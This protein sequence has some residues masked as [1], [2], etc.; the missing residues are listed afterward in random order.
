MISQ[1]KSNRFK[2]CSFEIQFKVGVDVM[3]ETVH[4]LPLVMS[5][6]SQSQAVSK[7]I[8]FVMDE[9]MSDSNHRDE[10]PRR[11]GSEDVGKI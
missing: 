2:S 9:V 3:A 4:N 10:E 7:R 8:G 11:N 6:S 5:E 1:E